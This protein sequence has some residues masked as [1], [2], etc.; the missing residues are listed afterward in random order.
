[1]KLKAIFFAVS[2]RADYLDERK[3]SFLD[4]ASIIYVRRFLV[5]LSYFLYFYIYCT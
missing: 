4:P 1:M 3:L 5:L 2:L